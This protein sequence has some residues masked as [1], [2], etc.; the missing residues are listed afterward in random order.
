MRPEFQG[1]D[2]EVRR[3]DG[4]AERPAKELVKDLFAQGQR[5]LREELR[6]ARAE[7]RD[8]A[9][10]LVKPARDFAIAGVLAH[11]AL[12]VLVAAL[13]AGLA[14]V[15]PVGI[16]ALLVGVAL[17]AVAGVLA[18]KAKKRIEKFDPVPRQTTETI[19]ED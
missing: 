19:K 6:L 17:A 14:A 10:N 18:L 15:M 13:V 16:A 5:L 1:Y 3:T 12:L 4:A 2:P 7:M 9:K 11:T 8:E